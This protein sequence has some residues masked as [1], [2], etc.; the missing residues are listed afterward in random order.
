MRLPARWMRPVGCSAPSGTHRARSSSL[1]GAGAEPFGGDPRIRHRSAPTSTRRPSPARAN[2]ATCSR[3]TRLAYGRRLAT[4]GRE[5]AVEQLQ[6]AH[7][8]LQLVGATPWAERAA[9]ELEAIGRSR[10]QQIP[11]LNQLLTPHEQEVVEL[12]IT[13]A[14][15]RGCHRAVHEPQDGRESS[16]ELLPETRRPF[17]D[18][19]VPCSQP[20]AGS[21]DVNVRPTRMGAD[22]DHA[23][24][25]K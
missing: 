7:E 1:H 25:D 21:A 19:A 12:A 24:G 6:L 20:I 18:P 15:T 5:K 13:G 11:S 23:T 14:T 10:P 4:L 22:T 17:E 3:R 8:C 16:H 9:D 2:T